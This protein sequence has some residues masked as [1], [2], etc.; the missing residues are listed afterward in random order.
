MKARVAT[1][2][3]LSAIL[4]V[5]VAAGSCGDEEVTYSCKEYI[6]KMYD[7]DCVL[8]C[9][10]NGVDTIYVDQCIW[11]EEDD[12]GFEKSDARD[13]CDYM[14]EVAE[15][16]ECEK[17]FQAMLRCSVAHKKECADDHDCEDAYEDFI[18]C[19]F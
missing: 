10:N 19:A 13:I 9:D 6:E 1:V 15:D 17:E 8:W 18:D 5:F 16:E 7:A 11:F 3:L 2:V 14:E 4:T 12:G